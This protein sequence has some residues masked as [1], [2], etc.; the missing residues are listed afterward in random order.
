[1]ENDKDCGTNANDVSMENSVVD[2]NADNVPGEVHNSADV[3]FGKACGAIDFVPGEITVLSVV[4][5]E[6]NGV[7]GNS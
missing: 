1:M 4:N 2:A 7:Q 6:A 3:A 5:I